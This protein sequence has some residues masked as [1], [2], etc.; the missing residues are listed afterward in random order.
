MDIRSGGQVVAVSGGY[1]GSD[2]AKVR[3]LKSD[4]FLRR[5]HDA[6]GEK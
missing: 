6:I 4:D 3:A 1:I 2:P 5:F